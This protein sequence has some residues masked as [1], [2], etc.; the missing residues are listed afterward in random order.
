[1][2]DKPVELPESLFNRIEAK[3]KGSMFASVSEYVA[4]VLRERLESEEESSKTP[5]TE[6]EEKTIKNRLRDLGYL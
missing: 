3:I 1:M 6:E 4:F 5:F 2:P